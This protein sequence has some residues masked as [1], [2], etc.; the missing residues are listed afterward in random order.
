MSAP[1]Y[2]GGRPY[3]KPGLRFGTGGTVILPLTGAGSP[4]NGTSGTGVGVAGKGSVYLDQTNGVLWINQGSAT[5]PTWVAGSGSS[6]AAS[7]STPVDPTGTT[8]AT[9]VMMGV[10]GAITPSLTGRVLLCIN[11]NM[12]VGATTGVTTGQLSYGTG[13]APVNGAAVAGTQIGSQQ[14]FTGLTGALEAPFSMQALITGLTVGTAYWL[15]LALKRA[16]AGTSSV[17][18]LNVSAIEV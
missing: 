2:T 8:S 9:Y 16:V 5:S 10:A 14:A 6:R 13:T 18:A 3:V 11:G 15:D 4:V 1:I 17:A 12:V 7:N